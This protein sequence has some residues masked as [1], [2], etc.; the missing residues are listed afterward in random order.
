MISKI[1]DLTSLELEKEIEKWE[2]V[3]LNLPLNANKFEFL[4]VSSTLDNLY[5]EKAE[6]EVIEVILEKISIKRL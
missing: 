5:R 6:R 1:Q 4:T 2:K 3:K